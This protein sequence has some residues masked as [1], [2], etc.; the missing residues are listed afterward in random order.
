MNPIQNKP[1]ITKNG[2]RLITQ[3]LDPFCFMFNSLAMGDVIAAVPVVKY[4]T[5]NFYT[6]PESYVVVAKP[7]FKELFP[8]VPDYNFR[9]FDQ[10]DNNWD[11]PAGM[12]MALINKKN[13]KGVTRNTPKHMHLGQL[14]SILMSDRILP[15]KHLH[16][17][18]LDVVDVSRF[19]VP[20]NSVVLVTSYRDKTRMWHADHI[21]G[22][23][24]WLKSNGILPVFI[25]KTD[26]DQ[27][28]RAEIIPKSSLP[29]DI[30]EFG[31]D[32]RNKTTI[33]EL[34]SIFRQT[35]AVCG[36]DSGPIHLAGTTEVP[37]VCGYTSVAAEHRIPY[38]MRGRTIAIAPEIECIGCESR[39]RSNLWNYE[40]CYFGHAQCCSL[41]T[42]DRFINAL[43]SIL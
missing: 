4:M 33:P 15:E 2:N 6:T 30:G 14:A 8:F 42:P 22:V 21:L 19:N 12:V 37:I 36:L 34:A 24:A 1:T 11:L 29:N 3:T 27:N 43:S 20:T 26:M 10:K 31:L 9:N 35:R 38:R 41:M 18:P 32:L 28:V 5:E 40:N 25:G 16:Y 23:A 39:W 13:E 17:V 7:Y